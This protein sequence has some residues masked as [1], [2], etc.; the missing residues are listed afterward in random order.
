MT[1]VL[2]PAYVETALADLSQEKV[3]EIFDEKAR[4]HDFVLEKVG[5]GHHSIATAYGLIEVFTGSLPVRVRL[6]SPNQQKLWYLKESIDEDLEEIGLEA[7]W[8][9]TLVNNG[10][11]PGFSLSRVVRKERLNE[12]FM[13]LTVTGEGIDRF[14][15]DAIHFRL[16]YP[17]N[18]DV[19]PQWPCL[20]EARKTIWPSGEDVLMKP[21]YTIRSFD[22]GEETF[23]F[24]VFLHEGGPTAEWS[25]RTE[26]GDTVGLL[27]PAGGWMPVA[28]R[29][30]F[31]GDETA[32]PALARSLAYLPESTVGKVFISTESSDCVQLLEKPEAVEIEWFV[33]QPGD[34]DALTQKAISASEEDAP[35]DYVWFAAHKSAARAAKKHFQDKLGFNGETAYIA[36]YWK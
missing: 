35:Y 25:L 13:R 27:G 4:D 2:S 18:P 9:G 10:F 32:I 21:V 16:V 22:R 11:P 33:R 20:N 15:R 34:H 28:D 29:M 1:D 31:A 19:V 12:D 7:N 36:G 23:D 24:D 3:L 5:E 6:S 14:F 30:L 17:K 26:V 8:D